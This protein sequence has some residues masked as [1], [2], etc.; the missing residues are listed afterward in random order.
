MSLPILD[1]MLPKVPTSSNTNITAAGVNYKTYTIIT[2]ETTVTL[3]T[4]KFNFPMTV[5]LQSTSG[6]RKIEYSTDN[7]ANY[8]T[9]I[10][11]VDSVPELI[12]SLQSPITHIKA[13]GVAGDKLTVVR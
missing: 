5:T 3:L 10:Y 1:L 2:G 11:D 13:T 9:A 7:G 8:Q 6:T 4:G 12:V